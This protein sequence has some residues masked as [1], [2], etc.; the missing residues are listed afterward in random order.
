LKGDAEE[1]VPIG[2]TERKKR[3]ALQNIGGEGA[4][5]EEELE[6]CCSSPATNEPGEEGKISQ[7]KG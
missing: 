1:K 2:V 7:K 4:F 5:V 3:A 6:H